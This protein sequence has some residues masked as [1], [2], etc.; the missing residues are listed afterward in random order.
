MMFRRLIIF[1]LV[2]VSGAVSCKRPPSMEYYEFNDGSGQYDF[3]I[4]MTDSLCVY[5]LSFYTRLKTQEHPSSFP[6]KVYMTSP[7]GLRFVENV[8]YPV[9]NN[10]VVP[11]RTDLVPVEHGKWMMTVI[12]DADF[13]TGMG[14]IAATKK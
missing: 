10:C 5:D 7:S 9:G 14:L 12:T 3:E 2:I 4:D 1:F 8:F 13:I 11:Y 6:M